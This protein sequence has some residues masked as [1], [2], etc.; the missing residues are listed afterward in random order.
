MN[1]YIY[2]F[3]NFI[4]KYANCALLR[5]LIQNI[6]YSKL[7]KKYCIVTLFFTDFCMSVALPCVS[8]SHP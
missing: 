7:C 1:R 4:N 6:V 8:K 2:I 3:C 5:Y